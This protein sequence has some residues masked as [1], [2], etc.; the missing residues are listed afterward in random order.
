MRAPHLHPSCG[1]RPNCAIQI[2]LGP[3]GVAQFARPDEREFKQLKG[4][5]RGRVA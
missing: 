2:E 1:Y 4:D 3:F 5:A